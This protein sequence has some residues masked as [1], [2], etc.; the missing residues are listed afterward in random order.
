MTDKYELVNSHEYR[1]STPKQ[2]RGSPDKRSKKGTSGNTGEK[3][4]TLR[5]L[6]DDWHTVFMPHLHGITEVD[7]G[8]RRR[9]ITVEDE[10]DARG[11]FQ[12]SE[13][14]RELNKLNRMELEGRLG[15]T[16]NK[17]DDI[18]QRSERLS[19]MRNKG[20]EKLQDGEIK[21]KAFI[22]VV[23]AYR[24]NTEQETTLRNVVRVFAYVEEFSCSPPTY[25]M[26]GLTVLE[27]A[28]FVYISVYLVG[29]HDIPITWTGP[30]PY[31]S[32]IIYNPRR[33]WE[34]WRF[35][36]YM[37][38]HI[39]I[40]H[41]VFNMIMQI[42][43]GVF[44]EMEQSGLLGSL[45]VLL[46]Y[47]SGV[48][49]GSLGTSLSDPAT[50]IA[51]ASGGV[52]ALIAA[53]LATLALNWQEDNQLRIKKVVKKPITKIIRILFI[54][55]LCVHDIIYA[56]Y[57]RFYDPDNRTGFMGHL[58]GSLAGLTVGLFVLDNRRVKSWE[59]LVQWFSLVCFVVFVTFGVVWNIWGN[60]WSPGFFPAPDESLYDVGKC[61]HF[62]FM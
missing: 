43:V 48:L 19:R 13:V 14:R 16:P 50:Y 30:V 45:K 21:Y 10:L 28:M 51:G 56:V 3:T 7:H 54:V 55:I 60:E 33:R 8:R 18:L 6:D 25:A 38:V 32:N 61:R 52:Y 2:P 42:A 41:F 11:T 17:V 9:K 27:L 58:C 20:K 24:L 31:C 1:S 62:E 15:I 49:A 39:G 4:L 36:S 57:V 44:L 29:T 35:V 26:L 34:I 46:V 59:P 53:H 5:G 40:G 47:M 37:F 22:E 23:R 12:K